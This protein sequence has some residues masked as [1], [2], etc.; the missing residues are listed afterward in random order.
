MSFPHSVLKLTNCFFPQH[1][2]NK[3][4]PAVAV[5]FNNVPRGQLLHIEC[6]A[7][8]NGVVHARKERMGLAHFELL[9]N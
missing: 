2:L 7:W 1:K 8:F 5:K 3:I 6:K 9:V 4:S